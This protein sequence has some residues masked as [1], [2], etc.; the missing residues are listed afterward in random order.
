MLRLRADRA[1]P[2]ESMAS[3][4]QTGAVQLP[5]IHCAPYV[6]AGMWTI[7]RL[8]NLGNT[9][10]YFKQFHVLHTALKN[11]ACHCWTER[12]KSSCYTNNHTNPIT[13]WT[14]LCVT[15]G[16]RCHRRSAVCS[17]TADI[18]WTL[19]YCWRYYTASVALTDTHLGEGA[20]AW[21]CMCFHVVRVPQLAPLALFWGK[22]SV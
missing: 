19:L 2:E 9:T 8:A 13:V 14:V 6:C 12:N 17:L 3:A 20:C 16:D 21:G 22:R 5:G 15:R 4:G 10:T 18:L 7:T 1:H 11:G